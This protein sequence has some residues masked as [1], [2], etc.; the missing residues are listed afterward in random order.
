MNEAFNRADKYNGG[1]VKGSRTSDNIY[2]QH[3]LTERQVNLGQSLMVCFVD[4]SKAFDLINRDIHFNN[5]IKSGPHVRVIDTL[6]DQYRKT[7][8][9]IKHKGRPQ[10]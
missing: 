2:A 4:F 8:F 3:S 5:I 10:V 9:R 7:A 1:L 6:R